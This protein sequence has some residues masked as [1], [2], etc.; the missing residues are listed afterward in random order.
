MRSK[1]HRGPHP[2]AEYLFILWKH[3]ERDEKTDGKAS[4]RVECSR[5]SADKSRVVEQKK[6]LWLACV[7][8]GAQRRVSRVG[9]IKSRV[10]VVDISWFF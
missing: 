4:G 8:L 7:R 2:P 1:Q 5:E 3:Y 6:M 10:V 9:K